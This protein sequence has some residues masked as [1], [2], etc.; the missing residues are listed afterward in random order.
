MRAGGKL[1][2]IAAICAV[3]FLI[4]FERETRRVYLS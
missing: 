1:F 4:V 3:V 2:M